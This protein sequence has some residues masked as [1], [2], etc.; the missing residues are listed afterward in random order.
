MG[1]SSSVGQ[2]SSDRNTGEV[3][4]V[5]Q[6]PLFDFL[7]KASHCAVRR[8]RLVWDGISGVVSQDS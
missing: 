1:K 2:G 7:G 8:P 3:L 4:L 6:E 5:L